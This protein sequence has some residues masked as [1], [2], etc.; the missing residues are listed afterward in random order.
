[1][2]CEVARIVQA[3]DDPDSLDEYAHANFAA[4]H[5]SDAGDL[6]GLSR[7]DLVDLIGTIAAVEKLVA[8]GNSPEVVSLLVQTNRSVGAEMEADLLLYLEAI[9]QD[10]APEDVSAQTVPR[11]EA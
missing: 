2:Y 8:M 7:E 1:M 6:V 5:D 4:I 3:S 10:R 9:I 11:V